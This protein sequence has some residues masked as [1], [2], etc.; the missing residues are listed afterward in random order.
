MLLWLSA[1]E[2]HRSSHRVSEETMKISLEARAY[3][4]LGARE[5][6]MK[7]LIPKILHYF[8][9]T[10]NRHCARAQPITQRVDAGQLNIPTQW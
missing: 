10:H 1:E 9:I 4:Q 8:L 6:A 5:P 2:V 7:F 3:I